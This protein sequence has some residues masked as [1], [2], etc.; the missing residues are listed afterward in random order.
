MSSVQPHFLIDTDAGSDDAVA[1]I[2]ALKCS[3][4]KVEAITVVAGNVPIHQAVQNALYVVELCD[5]STP[6]YEGT[7]K[8]L[9]QELGTAQ[10]VHGRDGMGDIGLDLQGRTPTQGNAVDV[11]VDTAARFPGELNVVTL[12]PLTNVAL[13]LKKRPAISREIKKCVIMGGTGDGHGNITPVAEYNIWADPEAA[14]VVFESGMAITMVGWD[15][16]RKYACINSQEMSRISGLS[17]L[18]GFC[19]D[20][21]KSLIEFTSEVTHLDGIDL[22]DPMAMAI[23]IRPGI[24]QSRRSFYVQ[25]ET[26]NGLCRGQAVI[27][28]LG[29]YG[30]PSNLEMILEASK[31]DFLQFL[32]DTLLV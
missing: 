10:H 31:K 17:K 2:M 3:D 20:I 28:R 22:P 8:P 27:D 19:M 16:S 15:I 7:S 30:Q 13:A 4:I 6:V 25:V 26:G 18:G 11:I 1:I 32:E 23:A 24:A 14:Q 12:G 29:V 9:V 21:Q 5:K